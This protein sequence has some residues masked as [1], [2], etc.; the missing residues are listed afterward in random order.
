[1]DGE[2]RTRW[3]RDAMDTLTP[4]EKDIIR[5]RFLDDDRITLAEIGESY[6]VTK[7][8]IRQIEG[9]A[10]AKLKA[11]LTEQHGNEAVLVAN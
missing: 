5:H 7:E 9:R 8:R 6:G 3:L 4:R 11:V 1:M 10:L 2:T